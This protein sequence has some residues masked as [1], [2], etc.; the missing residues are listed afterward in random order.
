MIRVPALNRAM[1]IAVVGTARIGGDAARSWSP[2]G[3]EVQI[4]FSR[5]PD[6]LVART[7]RPITVGH[8]QGAEGRLSSVS[9]ESSEIVVLSEG[10]V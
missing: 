9:I 1:R 8:A 2:W 4:G 6:R 7:A 5:H 10:D 3:H